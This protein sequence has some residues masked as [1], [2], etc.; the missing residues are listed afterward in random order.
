MAPSGGRRT[1]EGQS[2]E[3]KRRKKRTADTHDGEVCGGVGGGGGGPPPV[4]L[5]RNVEPSSEAQVVCWLASS[6]MA[7]D[8][9]IEVAVAAMPPGA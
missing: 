5:A 7:L 6:G 8:Q 3:G 1:E 9:K 2:E 4:A